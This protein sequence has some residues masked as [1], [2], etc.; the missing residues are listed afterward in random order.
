MA[1]LEGA[2][3]LVTG[4]SSGIGNAIAAAFGTEGASVVVADI[5]RTPKLGVRDVRLRATR[6][7]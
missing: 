5:R 6:R 7:R 1:R 3:A 2:V 4:G